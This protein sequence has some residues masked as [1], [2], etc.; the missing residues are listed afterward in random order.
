MESK[1]EE[2]TFT[3]FL[4]P[5]L[6]YSLSSDFVKAAISREIET[7]S[8][9]E[10]LQKATVEKIKEIKSK[11]GE[12]FESKETLIELKHDYM[13]IESDLNELQKKFTVL[14]EKTCEENERLKKEVEAKDREIIELYEKLERKKKLFPSLKRRKKDKENELPIKQ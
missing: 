7:G 9:L 3:G 2:T 14:Q 13:G 10:K 11:L 8:T 12:V 6:I 1:E 5:K 4:R